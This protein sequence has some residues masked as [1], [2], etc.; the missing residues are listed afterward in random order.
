MSFRLFTS[1]T[2]LDPFTVTELDPNPRDRD[3]V[4][5]TGKMLSRIV[6]GVGSEIGMFGIAF[7]EI[8][9][10][11]AVGMDVATLGQAKDSFTLKY[12][13]QCEKDIGPL[14]FRGPWA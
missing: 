10:F 12:R 5:L 11:K 2:E 1:G 6:L 7:T 4:T 8:T 14:L 13:L 9:H 3:I